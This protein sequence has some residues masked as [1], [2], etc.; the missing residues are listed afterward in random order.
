MKQI[1]LFYAS[2]ASDREVEKTVN[3]WIA[4]NNIDVIDVK[5][6]SYC[7]PHPD[8]YRECI[9]VMVIYKVETA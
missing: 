7:T 9:E 1:K 4:D 5:F 3:K 2:D 8:R 6:G